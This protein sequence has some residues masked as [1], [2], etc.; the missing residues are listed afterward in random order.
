LRSLGF[1]NNTLKGTIPSSLCSL[2]YLNG[3]IY[4]DCGEITCVSRCCRGSSSFCG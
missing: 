2:P 1:S 3:Y 4:I